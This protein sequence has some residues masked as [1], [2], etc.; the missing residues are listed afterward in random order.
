MNRPKTVVEKK[1]GA[2]M[3][4]K[5]TFFAER[6]LTAAGVACLALAGAVAFTDALLVLP[7]VARWTAFG[8]LIAVG[9]AI[10]VARFLAPSLRFHQREAIRELEHGNEEVGQMIRTSAQV[11]RM[12]NAEQ[13]GISPVLAQA[14]MEQTEEQMK[15]MDVNRL[16]PWREVRRWGLALAAV[17]AI[18]VGV[19]FG[20]QDFRT[21]LKRLL[22][23]AKATTFTHVNVNAR[24]VPGNDAEKFRRGEAFEIEASLSG[25]RV[26]KALLY[27]R[28][29]DQ[30]SAA[31]D[32]KWEITQMPIAGVQFFKMHIAG[33]EKSFAYF[34][35]AGDAHSPVR[36]ARFVEP[37]VIQEVK[38]QL[39]YP[40]YTGIAPKEL[41]TGD[42]QAVEGTQAAIAFQLNHPLSEA[43]LILDGKDS[44]PVQIQDNWI[45]T[46][47]S[48]TVGVRE[49]YL[50]GRDAD[51][52]TLAKAV[53]RMKGIEDKAPEV[54]LIEPA[55]DME[56]TRVTEFPVRI[57][58][59]DDFGLAEVGIVL[60]NGDEEIPLKTRKMGDE[61]VLSAQEIAA[62]L[63]EKFPLTLNS[64]VR[65]YAY[66]LD[67]KPAEG[68][69]GER[70][71]VSGLRAIDIRP[72]K[73][74]YRMGEA[75][76]QQQMT[77][78]EQQQAQEKLIKLD[79]AVKQQREQVSNAFKMKAEK[80]ADAK[81]AGQIA[82]KEK[83]L[84]DKVGQLAE[85]PAETMPEDVAA[86]LKEASKQMANASQD[87]QI[88]RIPE[89]YKDAD[90]AL[91]NLL[92]ARREM[93]KM[94]NNQQQQQQNA[95]QDEQQ[96][97]Q[98]Q[99]K[100]LA[101]EAE[102]LA[103]EEKQVRQQVA[104]MTPKQDQQQQKNEKSQSDQSD[105][106]DASDQ[107]DQNQQPEQNQQADNQKSDSQKADAQKPNSQKQDGQKSDSQKADAQKSEGQKQDNQRADNQ[108]TDAQKSD[109]QKQDNQKAD[110]QK[111]DAQKSDQANRQPSDQAASQRALQRQ[112]NATEDGG[113]LLEK[114]KKDAEMTPLAKDRMENAEKKM[115]EATEKMRGGQM[116]PAKPE[117]KEAEDKLNQLAEH[118]RGL[119]SRNL[120]QTLDAASK[121]AADAAEKLK[122][123]EKKDNANP[124]QSDQQ[125]DKKSPSDRS[126]PSD[127][128][129]QSDQN[130]KP[131]QKSQSQ[132]NAQSQQKS[133]S[134]QNAQSQQGD[135][136]KPQKDQQANAQNQKGRNP[137]NQERE[138]V[139]QN[140]ETIADWLQQLPE[141]AKE[142][143][144]L[145]E[146]LAQIRE[147][148]AV[149]KLAED[150]RKEGQN[151]SSAK[152]EQNN[153]PAKDEK[154]NQPAKDEKS[155]QPAKDEKSDQPSKD[156]NQPSAKENPQDKNQD[157]KSDKP[158][159]PA[160]RLEKL[161]EKLEK[162][163]QRLIQGLLQ[164]LA[165]T[166]AKAEDLKQQADKE[167]NQQQS[168]Q[169][170][171]RSPS[172]R[173]DPSDASDKSDQSQKPD[174]N[175]K[176]QSKSDSKSQSQAQQPQ[177]Q[178]KDGPQGDGAQEEKIEDLAQDLKDLKDDD[179]EKLAKKM[180]Q[181]AAVAEGGKRSKQK[182]HYS[183]A[184]VDADK[185][186]K[187]IIGR[188][189]DLIAQIVQEQML[190]NR[191]VRVPDKYN[192][193]VDRYFKALSDDLGE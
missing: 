104:Q 39:A 115:Q 180:L 65:L 166:E 91:G 98:E 184:R 153:Q 87:F 125:Q 42:V 10:L 52:L 25:R 1:I 31:K 132:Q 193:L 152:E 21:G 88:P 121:K 101:K 151:K 24:S 188:L 148:L 102:R 171:K 45:F 134:Q 32:G 164:K 30:H 99:N 84:S 40:A 59:K 35:E 17:A 175:S 38:A 7:P 123:Q 18:F 146:R 100:D 54:E 75:Q 82:D 13:A 72:F 63:L 105:P 107:S 139:A 58:A 37:P 149:D 70:R 165:E 163:K 191:D 150:V 170:D 137:A 57:R 177:Q 53:Y 78:E 178:Q 28:T 157:Q 71:G 118:L 127:A 176:S 128:S 51:D 33:R 187:P 5:K 110:S 155:D 114:M 168:Q 160:E 93:V 85:A 81:K 4:R 6:A 86:S 138:K 76:E 161:A 189:K 46:T 11:A 83:D 50:E 173:S 108:K 112:E 119:E 133:Q 94:L 117:L 192:R 36:M 144:N 185:T 23:P 182:M 89:G 29:K 19:F 27:M 109:S 68:D 190:I 174:Q 80:K 136:S 26:D 62:A 77:P 126:D 103:R 111:A 43:R 169:Q 79:S 41:K 64:N 12:A 16:I 2:Y 122:E 95:E 92:K 141:K 73:L 34:V 8:V 67:K 56:V 15:R 167:K 22:M 135:P 44:G 162:E 14:L 181:E 60:K 145:R 47:Q 120:A 97:Q 116:S 159:K 48:L 129:D 74:K 9:A 55:R 147:D 49:Y 113:E 106:S 131:E 66:A 183:L 158:Q 186:L 61:I 154:G 3:R 140:A 69:G 96:D 156:G 143:D 142:Q 20:W 130:Q 90:S 179:L 172:D 124:Q